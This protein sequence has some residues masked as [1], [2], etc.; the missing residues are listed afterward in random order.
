MEKF[1][2]FDPEEGSMKLW[3]E[4]FE[5]RCMLLEI[6]DAKK[7]QWCRSVVGA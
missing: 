1:H 4:Q 7:G 3:T 2:A 5:L 6:P